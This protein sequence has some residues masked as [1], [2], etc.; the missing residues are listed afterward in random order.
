MT[1]ESII[2]IAGFFG[3]LLIG[4]GLR[5]LR[6]GRFVSGGLQGFSGALLVALAA[7]TF[8]LLGNFYVYHRLTAEQPLAE[9][10][11]H[12]WDAQ[13]Y[14][15]TIR[16]PSGEQHVFDVRGDDWQLDAR[17]LKWRGYA[18]LIGFDTAYRLDRL[19]GRYRAVEQERSDTRS[20]H[21]L[22]EDPR[23]DLW[24]LAKRYNQWL[25][26]VDTLY[27]SAAYLPMAD[28]AVYAVSVTQSGLV[29]RPLNEPARKAVEQWR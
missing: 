20:I 11:F 10:R 19:S 4:F 29:A 22:S 27:G 2:I 1:F 14:Q 9:L 6:R 7:L 26:W 15:A 17:I 28:N 16:Y 24:T 23:L 8:S 25:P 13:H 3:L 21:T 5:R 12:A 18:T